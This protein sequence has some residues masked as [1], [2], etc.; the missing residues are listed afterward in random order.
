MVVVMMVMVTM[1]GVVMPMRMPRPASTVPDGRH[2]LGRILV[3]HAVV[4]GLPAGVRARPWR[5]AEVAARPKD[6]DQQEE[7]RDRPYHYP[8]YCA[9]RQ[10]L[11]VVRVAV[12]GRRRAP[13]A[14]NHR[15]RPAALT[16]H[17]RWRDEKGPRRLNGPH[18]K[19]LDIREGWEVADG[20]HLG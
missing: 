19:C 4:P 2:M 18:E 12:V 1:G 11:G 17:E 9:A 20:S 6:P 7:A 14:R 15:H 13:V 8:R 5:R 3:P 10:R 16:L